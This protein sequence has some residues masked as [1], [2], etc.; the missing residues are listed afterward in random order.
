[1]E[2][3]GNFTQ[4][5]SFTTQLQKM[6]SLLLVVFAIVLP[7]W[8]APSYII[9]GLICLFWLL[10][11]NLKNDFKKIRNNKLVWA[12]VAYFLLHIVG[13][14]WTENFAEG[15]NKVARASLFLLVPVFMMV[16]KEEHVE[17]IIWSF[18]LSMMLSCIFSLII[19]FGINPVHFKPNGAG[20]PV[21]F[22]MHHTHYSVYLAI[23]IIISL[24][25]LLFNKQEGKV[26]KIIAGIM[27]VVFI[28]DLFICGGRTGQ[29]IFFVYLIVLTFKY[30][31]KK[32]IRAM[33]VLIIMV[34][35]IFLFAFKYIQP[36]K[37][38][39]TR[40][41]FEITQYHEDK[42]TSIGQRFV[43]AQNSMNLFLE[44][45]LTGV[46]TGDFETELKK[47]HKRDTP[48]IQFDVDPHNMFLLEMG[49]FGI[50]GLIS[51]LSIFYAQISIAL[52]SKNP[53]HK[54][55]GF[56]TPMVFAMINFTDI[57]L[58]L[59]FPTMLF[60]LLSSILYRDQSRSLFPET[61]S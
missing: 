25:Y 53:V 44:H 45:P 57:C 46:G 48:T 4:R 33:T 39:A 9:A 58:Q 27:S 11:G 50:L 32:W 55:L 15:P 35:F 29:V 52:Q 26:N 18:L 56:I 6:N 61:T 38:R 43:Y 10:Q 59:H 31:G 22:Q 12:I 3:F 42:K 28:Y 54:F 37:D 23:S 21:Y 16:L 14:L 19:Y 8:I 17:A 41:I 2:A 20:F 1:M 34:P 49:Q 24:Y 13:L 30:F 5:G 51:F 36:F 7:M 40:A 60:I 47:I